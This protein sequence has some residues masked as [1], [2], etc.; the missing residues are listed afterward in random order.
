MFTTVLF[1]LFVMCFLDPFPSSTVGQ[2]GLMEP[3]MKMQLKL[4]AI[5]DARVATLLWLIVRKTFSIRFSMAGSRTPGD[6]KNY[7]GKFRA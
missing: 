7:G 1:P 5:I 6:I 4:V 2:F 3:E